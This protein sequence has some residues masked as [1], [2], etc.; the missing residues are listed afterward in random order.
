MGILS[1]TASLVKD[2][3][4]NY[5][6]AVLLVSQMS[7]ELENKDIWLI[8]DTLILSLAFMWAGLEQTSKM[9]ERKFF[10]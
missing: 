5:M 2:F 3:Y 7:W 4:N 9:V 1:K 6:K 10:L 8:T